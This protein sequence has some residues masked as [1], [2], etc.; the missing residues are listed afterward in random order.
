M[1]I[2]SDEK[3]VFLVATVTDPVGVELAIVR[4]AVE[5]GNAEVAVRIQ[6]KGQNMQNAIYTTALRI[7]SGL[8]LIWGLTHQHFAPSIFILELSTTLVKD[9]S[10]AILRLDNS[11][12]RR[13][14]AVTTS[15]LS[16]FHLI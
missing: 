9:V 7:L 4:V 6:P 13:L 1:K 16:T 11:G 3:P 8:Y 5:I 14:A 2:L 12:F 10:L 15:S